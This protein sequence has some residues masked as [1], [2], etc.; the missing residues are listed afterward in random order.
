MASIGA[1]VEKRR[2]F[3]VRAESLDRRS[4]F[5]VSR[6]WT[7]M[8]KRYA[9]APKLKSPIQ[10]DHKSNGIAILGSELMYRVAT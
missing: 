8:L 2:A 1:A 7:S 9:A 5:S 4:L 10:I 3:S 6:M